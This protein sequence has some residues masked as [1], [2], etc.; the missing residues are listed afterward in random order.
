ML[1]FIIALAVLNP[2]LTR[3]VEGPGFV[4]EMNKE[5]AK[6]LHL[7]S[8][9]YAPIRRTGF[10][11]A[12]TS[13]FQGKEGRKAILSLDAKNVKARFNPWGIFLR[14]WQLDEVTISPG[15]VKI[16]TYEPKPEPQSPKPWYAFLMPDRVYLGQVICDPAD[17]TWDLRGQKSGI[18]GTHLLIT[19][20][21]RDFEYHAEGGMLKMPI[22][23]ELK[24]T[25]V[26]LLVTKE[27]FSLY[28]LDLASPENTAGKIRVTGSAG[29][30]DDKSIK[31]D[32]DFSK[33]PIE[34]WT[35][36]SWHG[37]VSGFAT[38]SAHWQGKNTK[39]ET[40]SGHAELR[41]AKGRV[42]DLPFLQ[43]LASVTG[44]KSFET[45]TL[46]ECA[47]EVE[48]DYPR[49]TFKKLAIEDGGKF[50]IEGAFAIDHK[51]L[52]GELRLGLGRGYLDWLPDADKIFTR[53]QGGYLWATIHLSG[54]VEKPVQD[55]SPR[56]MTMLE[57]HPG[58]LLEFLFQQGGEGLKHL[59]NGDHE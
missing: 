47:A 50:R 49:I 42:S 16:H 6:G 13:G 57:E 23:P 35:P 25:A 36:E 46:D 8:A 56:I 43:K 11:T 53:S 10:F 1:A 59:F 17:V 9:S 5:T 7:E 15:V 39:M 38:G 30:K 27:L 14:R 12:E 44:K 33:L 3:Y 58:A 18:F 29:V 37:H 45:L 40:A 54:T 22:V 52:S 24:V 51:A 34:P 32:A 28:N 31:A 41:I 2:L 21:G 48:W 55:L 26:H 4:A 20:H 19:P